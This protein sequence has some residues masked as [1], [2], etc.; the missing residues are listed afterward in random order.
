MQFD[1][2][3]LYCPEKEKRDWKLSVIKEWLP[4]RDKLTRFGK[5][6]EIFRDEKWN[7]ILVCL[8][9]LNNV[10]NKSF[11]MASLCIK[12]CWLAAL[13]QN[14]NF[15]MQ[16]PMLWSFLLPV[17]FILLFN[18]IVFIRISVSVI[19]K[20]NENL[21]RWDGIGLLRSLNKCIQSL[22]SSSDFSC[23]RHRF[24]TNFFSVKEMY[25]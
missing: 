2:S 23:Q 5:P 21:T 19:W 20:K 16:K 11:E 1:K 6:Y 14:G 13:D 4:F 22:V 25:T 7:I 10:P 8:C 9:I 17:A 18:I 24:L 3:F 15:S 12:S